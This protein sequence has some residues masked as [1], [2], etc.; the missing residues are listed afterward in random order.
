MSHSRPHECGHYERSDF[1]VSRSAR[2]SGARSDPIH[3][4]EPLRPNAYS[5]IPPITERLQRKVAA[6]A[7]QPSQSVLGH[8]FM[9]AGPRPIER[10]IDV[11]VLDGV[12][13]DVVQTGPKVSLGANL[14]VGD[15]YQTCRFGA[16]SRRLAYKAER[17]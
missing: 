13:D 4:V 9:D 8:T 3:R 1:N 12:F 2:G 14:A 7:F 11:A 17:P 15:L 16:A 10:F 6:Q 5:I